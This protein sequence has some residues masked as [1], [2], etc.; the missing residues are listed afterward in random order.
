VR[1][2]RI[3]AVVPSR[4]IWVGN[5]TKVTD[6]NGNATS[7]DPNDGITTYSYDSVNRLTGVDYSDSTPDV[8]YTYDLAGRKTSMTDG[9]GTVGYGYDSSDRLTSVTRSGSGFSY[10]YDSAGRLAARTYPDGTAT[11]YSYDD[12]SRLSTA[13]VCPA[14]RSRVDR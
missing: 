10:S 8:T 1:A 14:P 13:T 9:G 12:D 7:G 2:V 11:S 3:V 5:K 4:T 6:A